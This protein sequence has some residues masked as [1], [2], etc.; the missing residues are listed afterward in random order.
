M[1][2]FGMAAVCVLFV[3]ASA[4]YAQKGQGGNKGQAQEKQRG[5]DRKS[6]DADRQRAVPRDQGGPKGQ[7]STSGRQAEQRG[8]TSAP[9]QG[10]P[11]SAQGDRAV[12]RPGTTQAGGGGSKRPASG[13]TIT[14]KAEPRGAGPYPTV[15]RNERS[16]KQWQQQRGW[17]RQGGWGEHGTWKAHRAGRWERDHLTWV[18]RGGYG[19][20]FI[21]PGHFRQYFGRGHFFRIRTMPVIVMGYPRF[22]YRGY[23]FMLVDPWPEFW[24]DDWY[25]ADDVY[26]DY[27]DGYYLHN[28]RH[29]GVSIAISVVL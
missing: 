7:T 21:P 12:A 13:G 24:A 17:Q 22:L 25:A 11:S 15:A 23:W 3:T 29:P 19:G 20:F 9:S 1:R 2:V 10:Q 26:I 18:Q 16:V 8:R 6:G 14:G 5:G 4:G 27:D 28:R